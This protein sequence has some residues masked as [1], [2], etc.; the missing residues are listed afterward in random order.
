MEVLNLNI[1][2]KHEVAIL[3]HKLLHR[4]GI[5]KDLNLNITE[6]FIKIVTH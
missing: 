2:F 5:N 1:Y 4:E 3:L 6:Y